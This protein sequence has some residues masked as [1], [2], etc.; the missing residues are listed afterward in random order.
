MIVK[1]YN[2]YPELRDNYLYNSQDQLKQVIKQFDDAMLQSGLIR[3][4]DVGQLDTNNIETL[5]VLNGLDVSKT[6]G[7]MYRSTGTYV[8]YKPM[9]YCF[10][11]TLQATKPVCIKVTFEI[12]RLRYRSTQNTPPAGTP[13]VYPYTV[14]TVVQ[15]GNN[16]D[17]SCN[18]SNPLTLLPGP[19]GFI[20]DQN[21]NVKY[22][23]LTSYGLKDSLINYQKDKG[24]LFVNVC[25]QYRHSA[26]TA[27]LEQN[28]QF[29]N[30]LVSFIVIRVNDDT[31][32]A[33]GYPNITSVG[34]A[35]SPVEK[36]FQY[37]NGSN[38]YLDVQQYS[39]RGFF[40]LV[41]NYVNGKI[42][43]QPLNA[44]DPVKKLMIRYPYILLASRSDTGTSTGGLLEVELNENEK[45]NYM[46]YSG[47]DSGFLLSNAR[48]TSVQNLMIYTG[49][50]TL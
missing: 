41:G 16:T 37:I 3:S 9:V 21:Y 13:Q 14:S 27:V 47:I 46:V 31:I 50:E 42:V 49:N 38:I 28:E 39:T 45:Y 43:T 10:T 4:A 36:Y 5:D 2:D 33:F 22:T 23:T 40:D 25:P 15:V 19:M 1:Y 17:G 32:G 7:D 34:A 20:T 44:Y 6:T 30:S 29:N 24:L 48:S 26:T 18:I 11:D 8:T 12:G 35:T